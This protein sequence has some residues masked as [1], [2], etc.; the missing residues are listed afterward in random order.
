MQ[1][2]N[3]KKFS[4]YIKFLFPSTNLHMKFQLQNLWSVSIRH[5][6]LMHTHDTSPPHFTKNSSLHAQHFGCVTVTNRDTRNS[7]DCCSGLPTCVVVSGTSFTGGIE[8]LHM[9]FPS[10]VKERLKQGYFSGSSKNTSKFCCLSTKRTYDLLNFKFLSLRFPAEALNSCREIQL[11][12][13]K[14]FS[15]LSCCG[16]T[17]STSY[18]HIVLR[19]TFGNSLKLFVDTPSRTHTTWR[20]E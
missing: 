12:S 19:H 14:G 1:E 9:I 3:F 18:L 10:P 17:E 6:I 16:S 13:L 15:D 7:V 5:V 8:N 2:V 4:I 20:T 11:N